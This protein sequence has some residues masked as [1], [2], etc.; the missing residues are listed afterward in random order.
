MYDWGGSPIEGLRAMTR[1]LNA[2]LDLAESVNV[3]VLIVGVPPAFPFEVD[4]CL[5][6]APNRCAVDR[7]WNETARY[8]SGK[9]IEAAMRG[10]KN[11]R[12]VNLFDPLCPGQLCTAGT[13]EDP[14]LSDR[15]HLSAVAAE[16][17]VLPI[18][19]AHLDWLLG[20]SRV[21][22]PE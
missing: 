21:K 4:H 20:V 8:V 6:R 2:T 7:S 12:F 13:A 18:L 5:L 9:G 10:R 15:T 3:R 16:K 17:R 1:G 19:T 22:S 14:L 11:V